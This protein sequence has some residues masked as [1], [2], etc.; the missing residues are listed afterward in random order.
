MQMPSFLTRPRAKRDPSPDWTPDEIR[1]APLPEPTRWLLGTLIVA[2]WLVS[3]AVVGAAGW[4][5]ASRIIWP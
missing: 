5:I 1:I 4:W 2:F 3:L